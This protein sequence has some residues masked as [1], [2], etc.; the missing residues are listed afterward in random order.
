MTKDE[1]LQFVDLAKKFSKDCLKSECF[2]CPFSCDKI[3]LDGGIVDFRCGLCSRPHAWKL[4]D[5]EISGE[6]KI[7]KVYTLD[8]YRQ[9]YIR[10]DFDKEP[11]DY[12]RHREF[13]AF[14]DSNGYIDIFD[15]PMSELDYILEE[16]KKVVPVTDGKEIRFYETEE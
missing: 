5:I 7:D 15:Y 4:D 11:E 13:R 14:L 10:G 3:F 2:K 1:L 12:T 9:K 8:E 16:H 6:L